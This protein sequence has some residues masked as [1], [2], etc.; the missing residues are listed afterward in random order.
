MFPLSIRINSSNSAAI[1][2]DGASKDTIL[3]VFAVAFESAKNLQ[4]SNVVAA[5]QKKIRENQMNY[6]HEK[7]M[8]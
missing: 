8:A 3:M 7:V 1:S 2:G 6:S 4:I 5:D